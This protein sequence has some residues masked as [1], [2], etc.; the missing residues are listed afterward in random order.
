MVD[1]LNIGVSKIPTDPQITFNFLEKV[2]K[3]NRVE[4]K[5]PIQNANV[6]KYIF[7]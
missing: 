5:L 3:W 7:Q 4:S 1:H 2:I 6:E